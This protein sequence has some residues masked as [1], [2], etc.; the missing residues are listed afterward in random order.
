ML[1]Y[2]I[3]IFLKLP[4]L[5]RYKKYNNI[6]LIQIQIIASRETYELSNLVEC[7]LFLIWH[8]I[9]KSGKMRTENVIRIFLFFTFLNT[10]CKRSLILLG[11]SF[12]WEF[13]FQLLS[14]VLLDYFKPETQ[15]SF[16]GSFRE[17]LI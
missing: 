2:F 17:I 8:S 13:I 9:L 15:K 5:L 4:I 6:I 7:I 14:P 11:L 10:A 3:L 12:T 1:S 16:A